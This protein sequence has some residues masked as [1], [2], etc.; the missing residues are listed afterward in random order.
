MTEVKKRGG[1][2]YGKN[3]KADLT[4]NMTA[5]SNPRGVHID[6]FHSS[7]ASERA[8]DRRREDGEE[9]SN[10]Q[11]RGWTAREKPAAGP[12]CFNIKANIPS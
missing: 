4:T 12:N 1:R 11:C 3:G 8:D 2:G 10:H 6:R 7:E 9:E 5:N